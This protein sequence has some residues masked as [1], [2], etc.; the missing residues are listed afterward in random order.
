MTE[1]VKYYYLDKFLGPTIESTGVLKNESIKKIL[2]VLNNNYEKWL[3]LGRLHKKDLKEEL[4]GEFNKYDVKVY[5]LEDI[6]KEISFKGVAR[7]RIGR[8][9][10][11]LVATLIGDA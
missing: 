6:L 8:F 9:I 1:Q 11:L 10:Q 3:I 5:F 4:N 2:K 7:D